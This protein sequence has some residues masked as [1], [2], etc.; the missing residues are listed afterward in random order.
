MTIIITD[1]NNNINMNINNII[2][3]YM[4]TCLLVTDSF[5]GC[6]VLSMQNTMKSKSTCELATDSF[7]GCMFLHENNM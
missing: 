2:T 3:S 7:S 5:F 6:L 1:N 4:S